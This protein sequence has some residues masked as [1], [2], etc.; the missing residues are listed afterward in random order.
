M[1]GTELKRSELQQELIKRLMIL[2]GEY[3]SPLASSLSVLD[4]AGPHLVR[5]KEA[6]VINNRCR[7]FFWRNRLVTVC[8][9]CRIEI[10]YGVF[11]AMK[12]R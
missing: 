8:L 12:I 11:V 4:K 6:R 5:K 3:I 7:T 1:I 10:V 2:V 9:V